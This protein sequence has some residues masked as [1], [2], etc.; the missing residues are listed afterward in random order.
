MFANNILVKENLKKIEERDFMTL[1]RLYIDLQT[2]LLKRQKNSFKATFVERTTE[3]GLF[4][5]ALLAGALQDIGLKVKKDE[6]SMEDLD[7]FLET[8]LQIAKP[9]DKLN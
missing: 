1:A 7:F 6:V 8:L 3:H 2:T 5:S 4:S 9:S